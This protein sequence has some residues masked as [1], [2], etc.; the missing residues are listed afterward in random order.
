MPNSLNSAQKEARADALLEKIETRRAALGLSENEVSQAGGNAYVIRDLRRK[1]SIPGPDKI[2]GIAAKLGVTVDW[3]LSLGDEPPAPL[4]PRV[5]AVPANVGDVSRMFRDMPSGLPVYGTALGHN[6]KF[7]DNGSA[8]VEATIFEQTSALLYVARP[9]ALMGVQE[10]YGFYVQG[11][12]MAPAHKDGVL[13]FAN[14]RAPLRMQDD[15]VVQLR[16]PIDDGQNGEEIVCVLV[17]TLIKRNASEI[18]LEQLNPI[19]AS[20]SRWS[21]SPRSTA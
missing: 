11:D 4:P 6:I 12:S 21:A 10:A 9:P 16:A 7:G 18:T 15:V 13:R 3:L 8:E 17:K 20:R 2:K 19:C 14:P 5:E 1:A